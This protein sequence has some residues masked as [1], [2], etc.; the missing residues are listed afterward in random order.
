MFRWKISRWTAILS[1][2]SISIPPNLVD[3][4]L[5]VEDEFDI[6]LENDDMDRMQTVK[7]ALRIIEIKLD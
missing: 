7:D 5:D 2:G 1:T 6:T 4:V 3:I